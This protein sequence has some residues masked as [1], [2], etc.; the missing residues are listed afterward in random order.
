LLYHAC[1]LNPSPRR[2]TLIFGAINM[3]TPYHS[4]RISRQ[5]HLPHTLPRSVN[6][7]F[8]LHVHLHTMNGIS[9]TNMDSYLLTYSGYV[10]SMTNHILSSLNKEHHSRGSVNKVISRNRLHSSQL[11]WIYVFNCITIACIYQAKAEMGPSDSPR[12]FT[13]VT[14]LWRK[15]KFS[16]SLNTTNVLLLTDRLRG[17]INTSQSTITMWSTNSAYAASTITRRFYFKLSLLRS[18]LENNVPRYFNKSCVSFRHRQSVTIQNQ[19]RVSPVSSLLHYHWTPV[20]KH[21]MRFV[22]RHLA[23]SCKQFLRTTMVKPPLTLTT[24]AHWDKR[25]FWCA[26]ETYTIADYCL[27]KRL[28]LISND[29]FSN[30]SLIQSEAKSMIFKAIILSVNH[31]RWMI[32]DGS[33]RLSHQIFVISSHHILC[34]YELLSQ[35][36]HRSTHHNVR[37][38]STM[39]WLQNL[40]T[41]LSSILDFLCRTPIIIFAS[42]IAFHCTIISFTPCV[43]S[44]HSYAQMAAVT[45]KPTNMRWYIFPKQV[46]FFTMNCNWSA[47]PHSSPAGST[48]TYAVEAHNNHSA[49]IL[50]SA[51]SNNRALTS[52]CDHSIISLDILQRSRGSVRVDKFPLFLESLRMFFYVLCSFAFI[53]HRESFDLLCL[54]ETNNHNSNK[55]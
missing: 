8:T 12:H 22:Q 11:Q 31:P 46:A 42:I 37:H 29:S 21:C 54:L 20:T 50:L 2:S 25:V 39:I 45:Y 9:S 53:S 19:H 28:Q 15:T 32:L 14:F 16:S 36:H 7:Y 4:S 38:N 10:L 26:M 23:T 18:R 6:Q 34:T 47:S 55:Q 52:L 40:S 24:C 48:S 41:D 44:R 30:T 3:A 43:K 13:K 35:S 51:L 1:T 17:R 49:F 5:D 27:I 33:F